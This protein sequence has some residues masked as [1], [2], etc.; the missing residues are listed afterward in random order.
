MGLFSP[1]K[2]VKVSSTVYNMAGD[3][4]NRP[5]FLKTTMF[6][7][8][9]NPNGAYLGEAIVQSYLGGPGINQR[10]LFNYAV[11]TDYP[12]LPTYSISKA[13]VVDPEVVRPYITIP[14]SPAGLELSIQTATLSDGDYEVFA[15]QYMMANFPDEV[16]TDW[17]AEY[18]VNDHTITIQRFGGA[19]VNFAAGTYSANGRFVTA[20]YYLTLPEE[21]EALVPGT[22]VT[23]VTSGMPSNTGFTL[24]STT[25]TGVVDYDQD[26][27]Q[28]VTKVY[29]DGTPTD[30]VVTYPHID[31]AFNTILT[32]H[33]REV[34]N[35]GDGVDQQT[36]K[37][38]TFNRLWERREVYASSSTVVVVNDIGGGHTE[39]VTTEITGDFLRT[40]YDYQVDTQ[41][42]EMG[43]NYGG[44]QIFIYK[45]G[46]GNAVLD[47]LN[48]DVGSE[49]TAEFFPFLPI[50]LNNVSITA[51]AFADLYA[52]SERLY[53]RATKNQRLSALV[54]EVEANADLDDIDY[55][56]VQWAIT[57]NTKENEAKKY[58]Y[59]FWKNLI[60]LHG[61]GSGYLDTFYDSTDSYQD[62]IDAVNAWTAAQSN[63]ADPLYNT[64]KPTIPSLGQPQTMTLKFRTNHVDLEDFDNRVSFTYIDENTYS[65]LGKPGAKKGE[66]WITKGTPFDWT[67][68]RTSYTTTGS[69]T[70]SVENSMPVMNIYWQVSDS[71]HRIVR[72]YGAIF[73]NFIY[74]GKCVIIN[75]DEAL[76]DTGDSGF[77]IPLHMP[78]LKDAGL[79]SATQLATANT[80]I[81]F[82]SYEI[83]KTYWYQTFI[84]MLFIIVV[85][86]VAAALIAPAAIGGISGIFGTNAALGASLGLTGT[87]AIVAGAVANALA[88]VIISTAITAGSTAI[89]GEKWGAIVGSILSFAV[90]F[91]LAGGFSNLATLFQPQ[92]ILALSS[93]LA[94]GYNGFVQASIAEM[95]ADLFTVGE[96]YQT[97][98]NRI[99][100]LMSEMMGN[101]LAFNPMSLTDASK[102]NG[103]GAGGY[104]PESLD[105]FIQRTTLTGSDIVDLTLSMIN[106]FSDLSLTLPKT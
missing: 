83:F 59:Q 28:T 90:S 85:V 71:E 58:L 32:V 42:T 84:G 5:N 46:T 66:F 70:G 79:V 38:R 75:S 2:T 8:V 21:V 72:V 69:E 106:D 47:A 73:H 82:N 99:Q 54:A 77:L 25:N 14:G 48:V 80:Y 15:E 95:N 105:D 101:D 67:V 24:T 62:A 17:V 27:T 94:N 78:S 60:P 103:S 63:P 53:K 50:R 12:G 88:A 96:E 57:L 100:D 33:E 23:N 51:P 22:L 74:G 49:V 87:S 55:A 37:T 43:V 45:I 65:G 16:N 97:E 36:S 68:Y 86:V 20:D 104:L 10:L 81:V 18:N 98:M 52:A 91:G 41:D 93:S 61:L 35:G 30:I 9:M 31:T 40:V 29:T 44:S 3:E 4:I 64:T 34:Y 13:I 19:T 102:G 76:D 1:K 26:Q 6:A 11:R 92:N 89:F 39:T 56:Y 7:G